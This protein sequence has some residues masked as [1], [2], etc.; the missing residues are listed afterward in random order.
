[1]SEPCFSRTGGASGERPHHLSQEMGKEVGLMNSWQGG[2]RSEGV[3]N[4][5]VWGVLLRE[6]G[7]LVL[8]AVGC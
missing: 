2:V 3:P 7:F 5:W 8:G 6:V 4:W 1:M